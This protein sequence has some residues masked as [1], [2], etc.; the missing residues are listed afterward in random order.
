[1]KRMKIHE[2]AQGWEPG[3]TGLRESREGVHER[4]E[5]R[6]PVCSCTPSLDSC[7]PPQAAPNPERSCQPPW[8]LMA[9]MVVLGRIGLFLNMSHKD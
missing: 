4:T 2:G 8:I 6:L 1:M 5:G 7:L 3:F 9:F